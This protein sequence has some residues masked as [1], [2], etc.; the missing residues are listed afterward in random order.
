MPSISSRGEKTPLSPFRKLVPLAENAKARGLKVFHLNIGQPDILTPVSALS[1]LKSELPDIVAYGPAEGDMG[2]RQKLTEYYRRFGVGLQP[3]HILITSGASEALY[4]GMLSCFDQG[5]EIIAPEPFYANYN[6]FAHM[7]DLVLRPITCHISNGF[8]LPEVKDFKRQINSRTKGILLCNPNNPTG[9]IY[10]KSTLEALGEIVMEHDLFLFV[11]EVYREFVYDGQDFYSALCLEK[12]KDHV[13]VVDSV[14]KRY[15]ACG[16]R[17]G[18]L[19][20]YNS[21]VTD[22]VSRYAKLRL[23]PPFFGQILAAAA[24]ENDSAYLET[25]KAEYNERRNTVFRRLQEMEGVVSYLP[26]GAFYCF[27]EFPID[28]AERF[29]RWLLDDFEY[30]GSTVMLSPGGGFYATPELGKREVRIAYV[31]D[32]ASLESAMDVLSHALQFYPGRL[33]T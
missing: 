21:E 30:S 7:A 8:A 13:V 18:A 19:V 3:Q 20:S 4:L 14:S 28:D 5:D 31:L 26:G 2:Y 22:A 17:V 1:A 24:L 33:K 9:C 32:K 25:V 29:C 11:D 10:P 6:G 12:A 23:S 16:A 15:S 27:A